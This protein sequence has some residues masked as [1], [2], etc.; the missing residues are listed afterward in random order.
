MPSHRPTGPTGKR[1]SR[2]VEDARPEVAPAQLTQRR[3]PSG[4][5]KPGKRSQLFNLFQEQLAPRARK[6]AAQ[7]VVVWMADEQDLQAFYL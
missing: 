5:A 1:L 7:Q 3:A 2:G 6:N 4:R